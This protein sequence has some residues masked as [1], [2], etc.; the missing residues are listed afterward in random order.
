[1]ISFT[2]SCNTLSVITIIKFALALIV[3]TF[4]RN[5]ITRGALKMREWKI[6]Y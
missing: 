5:C 2:V 4:S 1:V 3:V 6:C